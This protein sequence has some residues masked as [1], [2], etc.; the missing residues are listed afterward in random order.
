MDRPMLGPMLKDKEFL[1]T[2]PRH[3]LPKI[4]YIKDYGNLGTHGEEIDREIAEDVVH[5]LLDVLEWFTNNPS[6]ESV[7]SQCKARI[8]RTT[9]VEILPQLEEEY[10]KCL[11]PD[12]G[13]VRFGQ[14]EEVCY[15]EIIFNKLNRSNG[16][17]D[18]ISEISDVYYIYRDV[19]DY[20]G[21]RDYETGE[22]ILEFDPKNCLN[23]NARKFIS[24]LGVIVNVT[25]LFTYKAA[26]RL[27]KY[28]RKHGK[29]PIL[30][31]K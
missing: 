7:L 5:K 2:I 31:L 10:P 8:G 20:I 25:D 24:D 17:Q 14:D 3:I 30:K 6:T 12:I 13:F 18:T 4:T 21:E 16:S 26:N 28:F 11:E 23:E 1:N 22:L 9:Y 15:L 19:L 27:I 29:Y